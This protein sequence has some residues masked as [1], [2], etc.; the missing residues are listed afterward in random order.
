MLSLTGSNYFGRC[1]VVH[2]DHEDLPTLYAVHSC[3]SD[4]APDFK[5]PVEGMVPHSEIL[6][7][8]GTVDEI[9]ADI[10]TTEW[11]AV[12]RRWCA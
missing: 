6:E 12:L 8:T 2:A 7:Y 3:V 1:A 9:A 11:P 10:A 5:M 4:V